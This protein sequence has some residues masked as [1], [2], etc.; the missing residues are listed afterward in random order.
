MAET[1]KLVD[2]HGSWWYSLF[3]DKD[4]DSS[5]CNL[6]KVDYSTLLTIYNTFSCKNQMKQGLAKPR[7]GPAL[8]RSLSKLIVEIMEVVDTITIHQTP[9]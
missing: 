7:I 8:R 2:D 9:R 4:D 6:L 5:L 1:I 3:G